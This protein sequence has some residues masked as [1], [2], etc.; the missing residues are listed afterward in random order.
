MSTL[1]GRR[2]PGAP[3]PASG[4]TP[5][6]YFAAFSFANAPG[7]QSKSGMR[8]LLATLRRLGPARLRRRCRAAPGSAPGGPRPGPK[9]RPG[10]G[11][12]PSAPGLRPCWPARRQGVGPSANP[13][14]AVAASLAPALRRDSLT[15]P[16]RLRPGGPPRL[17][18]VLGSAWFPAF[19]CNFV[20]PRAKGQ[21]LYPL[22]PKGRNGFPPL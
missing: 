14:C 11:Y 2:P 19:K 1:E 13:A 17:R 10:P 4:G 7:P 18:A 3:P 5:A 16:W 22:R 8:A 20:A 21:G 15:G 6:G 12:S 9:V